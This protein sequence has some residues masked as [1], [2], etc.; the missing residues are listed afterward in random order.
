[1]GRGRTLASQILLAM[2][3]ILLG[4]V[5]LGGILDL[6]LT[7]HSLDQ[8]YE[9]RA[10]VTAIVVADIPDIQTAVQAQ[11]PNHVIRG[12]AARVVQNT[13]AAYVVVSDRDGVRYSHPNPALIGKRLEEPVAVLDGQDR[14]GIDHG[15]LGRS[16]NGKAPIFDANGRVVGQV[17]VGYL[18]TAVAGQV[19]KDMVAI[20]AYC[21]I[22]LGLGV[23]VALVLA[24]TIKRVTF[25][26]EL[27]EIASLLQEREAMLH[28]IKEGVIGFDTRGRITLL[29]NEARRLL[30]ISTAGVGE[31]LEDLIPAGRLR[32]VLDGTS[33]GSDQ[34]V[35][36]SDALLVVNRRPV[37]IGNRDAGSI[38]TLRDRTE[39]ESLMRRMNAVTGLTN[40][41]RAQEHEF[42][43]RLHVLSGL[44]DLGDLEEIA[45]YLSIITR[46][47]VSSAEDLRARIG[48]PLVAALLL[49]KISVATEAGVE[50]TLTPESSFDT[51]IDPQNLMSIIGN[52]VDNAIEATAG[53]PTPRLVTVDL[54]DQPE[55]RI[56]VTDNGPGV[57][58]D[59]LEDIFTDGFSTKQ[60]RGQMR[61]GI[62]LAL[63]ARLVAKSGGTIEVRP[64]PGGYFEVRLPRTAPLVRS[65]SAAGAIFGDQP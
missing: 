43:N 5:V 26:L 3:G 34:S 18:E 16:A 11:D 15:S 14:V 10:R 25:G 24:R 21:A 35:M 9:E 20:A 28:G 45:K 62:G 30:G 6:R 19:H 40:A 61:R 32:Q 13:G 12:L 46:D 37:V 31:R 49:A 60:P 57:A 59:R 48:S 1:M 17:S 55:L 2:V 36:T 23:V 42:T 64:G 39:L 33:G 53:V 44:A 47:Q 63:V 54:A 52:L 50:L 29:N 7:T 51:D 65:S 4:T 41:L 27:R 38:V 56:I 58:S 22:V 8:Q